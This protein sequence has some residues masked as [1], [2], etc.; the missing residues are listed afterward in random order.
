MALTRAA[1][2]LS[3]TTASVRASR[4]AREGMAEATGRWGQ[5]APEHREG[6]DEEEEEEVDLFACEGSDPVHAGRV[7]AVAYASGSKHLVSS[8]ADGCLMFRHA[9][10][11]KVRSRRCGSE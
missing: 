7:T 3:H 6:G 4:E 1:L 9:A 2:S 8:G 11:G 10:S 5:G